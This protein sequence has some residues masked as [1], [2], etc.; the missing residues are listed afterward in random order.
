MK[1]ETRE[2]LLEWHA[3]HKHNRFVFAEEFKAY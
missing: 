2:K 1:N 3:E